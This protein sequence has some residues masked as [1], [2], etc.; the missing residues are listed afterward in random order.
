VKAVFVDFKHSNEELVTTLAGARVNEV[1]RGT[2]PAPTSPPA[3][4]F[5][6]C[7][8]EKAKCDTR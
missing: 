6:H 7:E 4:S 3:T 1:E 8:K 2:T 5:S